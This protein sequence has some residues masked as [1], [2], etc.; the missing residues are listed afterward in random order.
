MSMRSSAHRSP[1]RTPPR[2]AAS[3]LTPGKRKSPFIADRFIPSRSAADFDYAHYVLTSGR[4]DELDVD[5]SPA[6]R[7]FSKAM[8]ENLAGSK[9]SNGKILHFVSRP[10]GCPNSE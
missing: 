4:N 6:K 5:C 7:E 2:F 8:S 9:A 3:R 1:H 10:P